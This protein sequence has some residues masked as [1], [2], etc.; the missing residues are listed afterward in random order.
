MI[1]QRAG[2]HALNG[3]NLDL[4]SGTAGFPAQ[5][6]AINQSST[7]HSGFVALNKTNKNLETLNVF[8][9]T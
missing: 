6:G 8:L 4:N 7:Q 3:C 9:C 2:A 5:T 1:A